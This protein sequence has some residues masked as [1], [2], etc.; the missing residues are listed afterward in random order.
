MKA[1]VVDQIEQD[2]A[3]ASKPDAS[4]AKGVLDTGGRH[5]YY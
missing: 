4:V 5:G 1:G 2:A 3:L